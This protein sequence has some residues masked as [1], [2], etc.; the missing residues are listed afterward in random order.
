MKVILL[1]IGDELI[2]GQS[3]DTNTAYLSGQ[4]A[5]LGLDVCRHVTVPDRIEAILAELNEAR[6]QADVIIATGGLGPTDDDLTRHALAKLLQTELVLH[7]PSLRQIE[8][9]F[10]RLGRNMSDTNR[11][12]AMIPDGCET[13]ENSLGTAPGLVARLARGPN[14]AATTA[15][16]LPG[17]PREMTEMFEVSVLPRLQGQLA[18][19]GAGRIMLSRS[20]HTVGAGESAI[21]QR[22]GPWL[23]RGRNP[24][25]NI[26]AKD[27]LVSLRLNAWAETESAGRAM[28]ESAETAIRGLLGSLIFG[29]DQETLAGVVARLLQQS[30]RTVSVAESCSGGWLAKE[31][32]DIPGAS[33]YFR[34]GW[35][36]YSNQAK[37]DFLRIDPEIL[38]TCGAV[39]EPVA[40]Q[41]ADHA[42]KL[43][44]TDYGLGVTGIAGPSG[45]ADDKP[46]GLVYIA[47]AWAKDV[48]VETWHFPG[49]R[50][51]VRRRTVLAAL[52]LLRLR[53]LEDSAG[54][55][56]PPVP[57][58]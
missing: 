23:A 20:L 42:R 45:G 54:L 2:F 4:L 50:E 33:D 21:A 40:R 16:F 9:F 17:V 41:M 13:M 31:L 28:I 24:L 37:E 7:E 19:A 27:S 57:L 58:E 56:Q 44:G 10:D 26:T 1:S 38:R 22:L 34:C 47:L 5:R 53:L 8:A 30:G 18:A 6:S 25:V 29:T 11:I 35:V 15:Y 36:A 12:Q 48:T 46:V 43:A 52:N 32:T 49:D 39:S 14:P 3:L 55:E 51:M